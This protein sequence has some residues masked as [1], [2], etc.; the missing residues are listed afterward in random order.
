MTNETDPKPADLAARILLLRG[1]RVILDSDLAH[2]YGVSTKAFNQAVR[3]NRGR[4]PADFLLE[5]TNQ[6]VASLRSQSVT[7]KLGRGEHRKYAPLVFTEHGAIMAATI[8]N[9]TRAEQMS[10][11]VVRAFVKLRE[12]S[13]VN[14]VLAR[15]VAAL[16]Q[17]LDELDADTRMQFDQV[18]EAILGLMGSSAKSQ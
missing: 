7:L 15:E 13:L 14:A 10:V 6:D 5:L 17:R 2:L 3:R 18:F 4:F 8:L 16:K 12:A 9:S 11:Y 1:R